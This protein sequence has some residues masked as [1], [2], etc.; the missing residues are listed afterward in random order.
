MFKTKTTYLRLKLLLIETMNMQFTAFLVTDHVMVEVLMI[1]A[2]VITLMPITVQAPTLAAHTNL[3]QNTSTA[4]DKHN[5]FLL[6]V[7]TLH[8]MKLKYTLVDPSYFDHQ[9]RIVILL[10]T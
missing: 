3:Q 5:P 6:E 8:P 1:C 10:E 9:Y 7:L 2:S 4:L